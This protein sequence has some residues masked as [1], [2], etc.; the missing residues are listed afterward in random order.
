MLNSNE[1]I[2]AVANVPTTHNWAFGTEHCPYVS[3]PFDTSAEAFEAATTLTQFVVRW[4]LHYTHPHCGL[5]L[6]DRAML[7][8]AG[9]PSEVAVSW[10]RKNLSKC[11]NGCTTKE[12]RLITVV[13]PETLVETVVEVIRDKVTNKVR[14]FTDAE[15]AE[16]LAL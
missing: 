11:K 4:S 1:T 6:G 12:S 2:F 10:V 16:A 3:G 7:S 14:A 5:I 13:N 15:L 8:D 9:V